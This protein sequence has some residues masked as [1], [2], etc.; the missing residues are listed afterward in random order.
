MQIITAL[1]ILGAG[2]IIP[3]PGLEDKCSF[4]T[5]VIKRIPAKKYGA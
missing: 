2:K 5:N 1:V 3:S 4:V